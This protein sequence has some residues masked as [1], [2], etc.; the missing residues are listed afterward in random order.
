MRPSRDDRTLRD[1]RSVV[2]GRHGA[3]AGRRKRERGKRA[4]ENRRSTMFSHGIPLSARGPPPPSTHSSPP[5]VV[6]QCLQNWD[7]AAGRQSVFAKNR[8][9]SV[10]RGRR[11]AVLRRVRRTP[12]PPEGVIDLLRSGSDSTSRDDRRTAL[13][14]DPFA[15][16]LAG[17][18]SSR[19][20]ARPGSPRGE[21]P[22]SHHASTRCRMGERLGTDHDGWCPP[23]PRRRRGSTAKES[24]TTLLRGVPLTSSRT[25]DDGKRT[26]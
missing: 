9:S 2:S 10:A 1:R 24:P 13:A 19:R 22:E 26:L 15:R 23:R 11:T 21:R 6:R 7:N 12:S 3:G 14:N 25:V 18:R 5:S 20:F 16:P 4:S 17:E 8:S